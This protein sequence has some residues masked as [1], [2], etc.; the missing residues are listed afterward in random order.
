MWGENKGIFRNIN[1]KT[2]SRDGFMLVMLKICEN[3]FKIRVNLRPRI[4]LTPPNGPIK[5][6]FKQQRIISYKLNSH[7]ANA[8]AAVTFDHLIRRQNESCSDV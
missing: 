8:K 5:N 4:L 3:N 6:R 7:D 2:C 1:V